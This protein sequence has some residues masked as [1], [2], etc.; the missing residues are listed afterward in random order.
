L[1]IKGKIVDTSHLDAATVSSM[2]DLMDRYFVDLSR[3]KF[4]A[5]LADKDDVILIHADDELVGFSTLQLCEER[6]NGS[7][8]RVLFSGDT[9]IDAPCWHTHEL[10]RCFVVRATRALHESVLPLYWL[11]ICGGYRTYRYLPIFFREFWPRYDRP[12]PA[13]AQALIDTLAHRRFRDSYRDGIVVD[14]NGHLR[15]DISP[16]GERQLRNPHV[17]YFENANPDH[18]RGHELVCLTRFD[19]GN[20]TR[21]LRKLRKGLREA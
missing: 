21:A 13:G 2:F 5:D 19:E 7:S 10:Q 20:M 17:A 11:L 1:N 16:I 9:V 6:I 18:V 14:A 4:E 3:Q 12:T 8:I 15:G